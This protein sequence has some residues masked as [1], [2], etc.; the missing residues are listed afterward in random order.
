[1]RTI[2]KAETIESGRAKATGAVKFMMLFD[3]V[4]I[5]HVMKE[6][7]GITAATKISRYWQSAYGS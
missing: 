7:M 3:F 6:L 2:Q 4:F 1:M 5:L